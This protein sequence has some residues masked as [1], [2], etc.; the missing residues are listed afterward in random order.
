MRVM[1][2][3]LD[4]PEPDLRVVA[5]AGSKVVHHQVVQLFAAGDIAK[6]LTAV[7]R[8]RREEGSFERQRCVL[9][10]VE[11][12]R[13]RDESQRLALRLLVSSESAPSGGLE[14]VMS[15]AAKMFAENLSRAETIFR[16]PRDGPAAARRL[17]RRLST[18]MSD[19]VASNL[20]P[21]HRD[22]PNGWRENRWRAPRSRTN[23]TSSKKLG[24]DFDL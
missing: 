10:R 24:N 21:Q 17:D 20:I 18:Q 4:Q 23:K 12:C 9:D 1:Q 5:D 22:D 19:R 3:E 13:Y 2:F 16:F 6:V 8:A 14:Q 15:E 11:N 7:R